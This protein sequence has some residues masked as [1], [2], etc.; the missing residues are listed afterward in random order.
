M[1][2]Y[3]CGGCG[4]Y[5]NEKQGIATNNQGIEEFVCDNCQKGGN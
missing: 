1:T 3:A 5:F 4:D 2:T